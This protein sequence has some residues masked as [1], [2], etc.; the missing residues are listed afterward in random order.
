MR[1]NIAGHQRHESPAGFCE[2][3]ENLAPVDLPPCRPAPS[4]VLPIRKRRRRMVIIGVPVFCLL[5]ALGGILWFIFS[6]RP[7]C[8]LQAHEHGVLAVAFSPDGQTLATGS[9]DA[10]V[11]LWDAQDLRMRHAVATG[12]TSKVA[13]VAFSRDGRLLAM[14]SDGDSIQHWKGNFLSSEE[15]EAKGRSKVKV[16][17]PSTGEVLAEL[18]GQP[19]SG[20]NQVNGLAFSPDAK[21][22]ATAHNDGTTRLWNLTT[23]QQYAC[24]PPA[25]QLPNTMFA[26]SSIHSV[27]ISPDGK[28]LAAAG[29]DRPFGGTDNLIHVWDLATLR[30]LLIMKGHS[31]EINSIVFSPDGESLA[32]G[33]G[34]GMMPVS[35]G[36]VKLWSV[37]TGQLLKSIECVDKVTCIAFSPDGRRLAAGIKI[38]EG[39]SF[40]MDFLDSEGEVVLWDLVTGKHRTAFKGHRR[41]IN[42]L[43]ISPDG[44]TLATG[45]WDGTVKFWDLPRK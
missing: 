6:G 41:G 31:Q 39:P 34:D 2:T 30:E 45:G 22:L 23:M 24:I 10:K 33:A 16:C 15:K 27:A 36:E 19:N 18:S 5:V 43:A 3:P 20:A 21:I 9:Y 14:A 28:L 13:A 26:V 44:E 25:D 40:G 35:P 1:D 42:S 38:T 17:D 7:R 37:R 29:R 11:S 4:V 32:S 12:F 8:T